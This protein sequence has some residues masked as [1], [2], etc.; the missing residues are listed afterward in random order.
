MRDAGLETAAVVGT[1]VE[2]HP[3]VVRVR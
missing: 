1:V 2:D 3:G